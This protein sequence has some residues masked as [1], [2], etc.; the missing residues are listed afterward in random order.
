M[1]KAVLIDDEE[2]GR[3][4]LR[5]KLETWCPDVRLLGEANGA[6][7]G[8]ELIEKFDPDIV[9]LDIEMPRVNGFGMLEKL[10]PISFHLVFTTAHDQYAIEAI[11]NR[12]FDYLLKPVDIEE[13]KTCVNKIRKETADREAKENRERPVSVD[14]PRRSFNRITIPT[15]EGLVFVEFDDILY[16]EAQSNYTIFHL[17]KQPKLTVSKTLKEVEET[18]PGDLFFRIHHSHIVN[19]AFIRKYIRGNGGHIELSDGTQLDVSRR[20]KEEFLKVI[21]Q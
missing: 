12:A 16:I 17:N 18:L 7:E 21:G 13:L 1:L 6:A 20:R 19:L 9:F 4:S 14:L 10:G 3:I 2:N 5:K 11:K 15:M 8:I